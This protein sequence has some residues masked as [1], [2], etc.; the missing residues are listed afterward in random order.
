MTWQRRNNSPDP[1]WPNIKKERRSLKV[2]ALPVPV[3]LTRHG[4]MCKQLHFRWQIQKETHL[5]ATASLIKLPSYN[6]LHLPIPPGFMSDMQRILYTLK[7]LTKQLERS[8]TLRVKN[9]S[10]IRHRRYQ[11]V[12]SGEIENQGAYRV[13]AVINQQIFQL[14]HI[15]DVQLLHQQVIWQNL[16]KQTVRYRFLTQL[17]CCEKKSHSAIWTQGTMA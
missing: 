1:C 15:W 6:T 7:Y 8:I 10:G 16:H 5:K 17:W 4:H 2:W 9:T 12:H 14:S 11:Y 13:H 3:H